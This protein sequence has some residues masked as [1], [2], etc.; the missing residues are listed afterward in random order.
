[1]YESEMH[2]ATHIK[3]KMWWADFDKET[4][5]ISASSYQCESTRPMQTHTHCTQTH[6]HTNTANRQLSCICSETHITSH[7]PQAGFADCKGLLTDTR[8]TPHMPRQQGTH[9]VTGSEMTSCSWLCDPRY[10]DDI[11][12]VTEHSLTLCTVYVHCNT[13]VLA[14]APIRHFK[15]Y[16]LVWSYCK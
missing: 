9:I 13:H 12:I 2:T 5:H 8:G 3:S 7:C 11:Y 16:C 15:G 6:W 1:M 10:R 4:C 14:S